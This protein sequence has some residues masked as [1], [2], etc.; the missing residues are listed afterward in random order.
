MDDGNP[1][2]RHHKVAALWSTALRYCMDLQSTLHLHIGNQ[3]LWLLTWAFFHMSHVSD[4]WLNYR[5][6]LGCTYQTSA[7]SVKFSLKSDDLRGA[8]Q[9]AMIDRYKVQRNWEWAA[10]L[11][12]HAHRTHIFNRLFN[13]RL[14]AHQGVRNCNINFSKLPWQSR[15]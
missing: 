12:A 3:M 8:R 1:A 2:G 15:K 7:E 10:A 4:V 5:R 6:Q 9:V 11:V 13:G 14:H